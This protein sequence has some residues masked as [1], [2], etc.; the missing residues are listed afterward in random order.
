MALALRVVLSG[1]AIT[2]LT[3]APDTGHSG[4]VANNRTSAPLDFQAHGKSGVVGRAKR[5]LLPY[6]QIIWDLG[7][8]EKPGERVQ[9]ITNNSADYEAMLMEPLTLGPLRQHPKK[10]GGAG[11]PKAR[12]SQ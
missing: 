7:R 12:P 4:I 9:D 11:R 8:D 10:P 6:T 5:S 1:L 3:I 2:L